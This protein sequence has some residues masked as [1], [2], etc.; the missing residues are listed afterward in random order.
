MPSR[1]QLLFERY[2]KRECSPQEVEELIILLQRADAEERLDEPMKK[3]WEALRNDN[4]QYD[5]DWNK[6]YSSIVES[7]EHADMVIKRSVS[8]GRRV[9]VVVAA[10]VVVA[11]VSL[12]WFLYAG[13]SPT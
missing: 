9:L 3:L 6:M 13:S 12:L 1:L 5:V 7:Q 10:L 8:P 4:V 2:L 11:G